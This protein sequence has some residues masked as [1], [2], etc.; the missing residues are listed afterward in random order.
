MRLSIGGNRSIGQIG[1]V[2]VTI[3]IVLEIN[4][5]Q[6]IDF[7]EGCDPSYEDAEM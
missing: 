6:P 1:I 2:L 4:I 5:T 7:P 3:G